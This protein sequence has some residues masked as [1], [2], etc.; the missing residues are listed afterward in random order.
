MEQPSR[1][2]AAEGLLRRTGFARA[3]DGGFL[4]PGSARTAG[5]SSG[6]SAVA[7]G[8]SGRGTRRSACCL[9]VR[10]T[11]RW[12]RDHRA[13]AC[14]TARGRPGR[15][16]QATP[17]A[18]SAFRELRRALASAASDQLEALR[19]RL[20]QDLPKVL[21]LANQPGARGHTLPHGEVL[22][23][24][25]L[26]VRRA[27]RELELEELR[28][29]G[30]WG[31]VDVS[32]EDAPRRVV[33]DALTVSTL[34]E[35]GLSMHLRNEGSSVDGARLAA[36]HPQFAE[37]LVTHATEISRCGSRRARGRAPQLTPPGTVSSL[38]RSGR[39]SRWRAGRF[40][41]RSGR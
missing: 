15:M 36:G 23:A 33:Y 14:R 28:V 29:P 34:P 22:S 37:L 8:P 16:A 9:A 20:Q 27:L 24:I 2:E 11:G 18:R 41:S 30:T 10:P 39:S 19:A 1:R 31:S 21:D 13:W 7:K 35:G 25:S 6:F 5:C 38:R 26:H 3:A 4:W 40:R 17:A 12:S 32:A